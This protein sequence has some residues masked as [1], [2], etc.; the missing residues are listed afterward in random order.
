MGPNLVE[1]IYAEYVW[2]HSMMN[3]TKAGG[4]ETQPYELISYR[5]LILGTAVFRHISMRKLSKHWNLLK[6]VSQMHFSSS[7]CHSD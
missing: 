1:K 5:I 3:E 4:E 6:T 7:I 2:R